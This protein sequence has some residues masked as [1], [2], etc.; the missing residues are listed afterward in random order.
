MDIQS[1]NAQ[2]AQSQ[3]VTAANDSSASTS[4]AAL[5][6]YLDQLANIAQQI[7]ETNATQTNVNAPQS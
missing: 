5:Q 3:A 6:T 7:Q 4:Q 1:I 2:T